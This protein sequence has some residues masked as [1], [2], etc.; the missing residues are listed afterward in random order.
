MPSPTKQRLDDFISRHQ[1]LP[2]PL[3]IT[4]D[5]CTA[6]IPYKEDG[7]Y[8]FW[9]NKDNYNKTI[10]RELHYDL[11]YLNDVIEQVKHRAGIRIILH[12]IDLWEDQSKIIKPIEDA[13]N[14]IS[15]YITA[16]AIERVNPAIQS[17]SQHFHIGYSGKI[18][19]LIKKKI[20][21][22]PHDW[23]TLKQYAQKYK[24]TEWYLLL[25]IAESLQ[26]SNPNNEDLAII[27]NR[28]KKVI[29]SPNY[30]ILTDEIK[31]RL[32]LSLLKLQGVL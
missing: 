20:T 31:T 24:T 11:S 26:A 7:F 15:F 21:G 6:C 1:K 12:N 5:F 18:A 17:R 10:Y 4:G 30:R 27:V 25:R 28:Y 14:S 32:F 3:L 29:Y 22:L 9:M 13:S 2:T 19:N 23:K 16:T 8:C